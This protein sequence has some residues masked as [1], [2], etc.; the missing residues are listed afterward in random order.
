MSPNT[1]GGGGGCGVSANEY[2]CAHG[3]QINFGD[4]NTYLTHD[5]KVMTNEKQ[6]GRKGDNEKYWSRTTVIDVLLSFTF[7]AICY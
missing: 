4:L 5:L 3:A 6:G 7:A 2:S 1:G